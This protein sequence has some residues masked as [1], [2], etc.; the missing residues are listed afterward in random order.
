MPARAAQNANKQYDEIPSDD[1][2]RPFKLKLASVLGRGDFESKEEEDAFVDYY[3]RYSLPRWTQ[4]KVYSEA[5]TQLPELRKDLHNN[6][7]MADRS[8]TSKRSPRPAQRTGAQVHD[9][10]G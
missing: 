5:K 4:Q 2:Q 8:A 10:P 3:T 7:V 6:L 1:A 9:R